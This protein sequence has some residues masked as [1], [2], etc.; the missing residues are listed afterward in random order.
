MAALLETGELIVGGRRGLEAWRADGTTHRLISSGAALHPRR[1]GRDYVL[2]LRPLGGYDDVRD[3]ALLELIAL[4][5]GARRELAQLPAFHCVSERASAEVQPYRLDVEDEADFAVHP[6]RGVACL[7]M[8][9][10]GSNTAKVRVRARVDLSSGRVDRWLVVGEPEC[11]APEGVQSGDPADD[12]VC[13]GQSA[14]RDAQPDP[15]AYPF[16]FDEEHVRMPAA[17]RGGVKRRV[18]GYQVEQSSPSGRWLLLAGDWTHRD[19]A[20]RRFVLLDRSDGSLYPVTGQPGAWPEP[21]QAAQRS[22]FSTPIRQAAPWTNET[23]VRWVGDSP[24]T[25]L[26]VLNALVVRPGASAFELEDAA[27]AR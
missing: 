5:N 2:A 3:G 7:G 12:G 27:L 14:A 23:D 8:M 16:S 18:R 1:F 6:D 19:I 17:P 24:A 25:E 13:W 21:L 11:G 10:A 9:D 26:L 20:Y 4:A 22:A 15:A